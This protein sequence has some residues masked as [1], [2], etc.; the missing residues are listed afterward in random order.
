MN[1][2]SDLI[3]FEFEYI[4]N[5]NKLYKKNSGMFLYRIRFRFVLK[6][7]QTCKSTCEFDSFQN[8]NGTLFG[9]ITKPRFFS[10]TFLCTPVVQ[11]T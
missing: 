2:Y 9:T 3:C 8:K 4:Q 6:T 1:K 7:A 11:G 5:K 10:G